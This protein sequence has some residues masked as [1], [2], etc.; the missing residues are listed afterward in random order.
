MIP[1]IISSFVMAVLVCTGP[2]TVVAQ[3]SGGT[4]LT[5][6]GG[7]SLFNNV[8]QG[9]HMPEGHGAGPYPAL[10]KDAKLTVAGYPI[11]L[12]LNGS[13]IMPAFG[14]VLTDQQIADVINYVRTHF[15]NS[16]KDRVAPADVKALRP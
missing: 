11:T 2:S 7:E 12:V 10:T 15:G 5:Y 13:K 1:R 3:S 4:A 9:C 16:Y 6:Q 8:C 14:P